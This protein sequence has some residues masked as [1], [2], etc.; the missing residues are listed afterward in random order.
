MFPSTGQ[1]TAASHQV[2]LERSQAVGWQPQQVQDDSL[3]FPRYI[4]L[5]SLPEIGG[6]RAFHKTCNV[7]HNLSNISHPY[8]LW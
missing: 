1:T 4:D 6:F 8:K 5:M 7:A 2:T 3:L